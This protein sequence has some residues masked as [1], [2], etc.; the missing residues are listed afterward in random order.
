MVP[1]PYQK[2]Q[3]TTDG[4]IQ[5]IVLRVGVVAIGFVLA[6]MPAAAFVDELGEAIGSSGGAE[7]MI[8]AWIVIF[9]IVFFKGLGRVYVAADH[10]G[11][12]HEH[13]REQGREELVPAIFSLVG[14]SILVVAISGFVSRI[15]PESWAWLGVDLS[16]YINIP[17]VDGTTGGGNATASA[18][19]GVTQITLDP[20][21]IDALLALF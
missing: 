21:V 15:F 20:I 16:Q 6:T 9:A 2:E 18:G 8:L 19:D 10:A 7:A 13:K 14:G 4:R 12:H 3:T 11:S 17:G 1:R 5:S